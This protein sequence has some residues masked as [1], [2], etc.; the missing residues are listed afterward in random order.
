MEN[1]KYYIIELVTKKINVM[2]YKSIA[3]ISYNRVVYAVL[4]TSNLFIQLLNLHIANRPTGTSQHISTC[5]AAVHY[6]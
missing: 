5:I 2:K 4:H 3:S 6:M 1:T